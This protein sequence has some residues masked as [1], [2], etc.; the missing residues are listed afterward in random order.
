LE[1]MTGSALDIVNPL[2]I[3]APA[4]ANSH[5]HVEAA[6]AGRDPHPAVIHDLGN[7]LTGFLQID[8]GAPQPPKEYPNPDGNNMNAA[9]HA[10]AQ[11][12]CQVRDSGSIVL[13]LRRHSATSA[14]I[15]LDADEALLTDLCERHH[16][17]IQYA[18]I[19]S[20]TVPLTLLKTI[21][22]FSMEQAHTPVV[23]ELPLENAPSWQTLKSF[24]DA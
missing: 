4:L 14:S 20:I 22:H 16:P 17:V 21:N 19:S 8:T 10:L 6:L 12:L 2:G 11:E 9:I 7:I 1:R 18:F 24:L 3:V 5:K 23:D 13:A 15:R